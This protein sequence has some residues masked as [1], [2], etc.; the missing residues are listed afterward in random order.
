[1]GVYAVL[2]WKK[3]EVERSDNHLACGHDRYSV[4]VERVAQRQVVS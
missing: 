1:M 4:G 2:V 3:G